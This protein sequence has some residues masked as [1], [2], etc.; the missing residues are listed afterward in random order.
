[1]T[2]KEQAMCIVGSMAIGFCS[3]GEHLSEAG[4]EFIRRHG[5]DF[6]SPEERTRLEAMVDA[7][8][9]VMG[10][11]RATPDKNLRRRSSAA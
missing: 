4:R 5:I 9:K 10:D 8:L 2:P 11:H 1:M 7:V 3:S 6:F